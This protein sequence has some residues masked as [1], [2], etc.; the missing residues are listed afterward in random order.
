MSIANYYS[1]WGGVVVKKTCLDCGAE[2]IRAVNL[3]YYFPKITV[4][5]E[6]RLL[7]VCPC[8]SSTYYVK[9]E[10]VKP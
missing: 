4:G 6:E 9:A 8:C 5:G 3:R 7:F 10:E 1:F 2:L